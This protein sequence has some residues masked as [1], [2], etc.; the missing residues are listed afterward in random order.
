MP[1]LDAYKREHARLAAIIPYHP[2]A[3]SVSTDIELVSTWV[4]YMAKAVTDKLGLPPAFPQALSTIHSNYGF[5]VK[6]GKRSSFFNF[7]STYAAK[8]F[9][10]YV[11]AD[12]PFVWITTGR[13]EVDDTIV[14]REEMAGQLENA[15][16]HEYTPN[17]ARWEIPEPMR[18]YYAGAIGR[19][20][21]VES[22]PAPVSPPVRERP[23]P[24][25]PRPA[26]NTTGTLVTIADIAQELS[27]D[28]REARAL[29]RK[30]KVD[31]PGSSW[32]WDAADA[33]AI[34]KKLAS[35]HRR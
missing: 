28:A 20:L 14:I 31:K 16:E 5:Y 27:I 24:T 23:K 13:I 30:A 3:Q 34:K 32:A 1:T 18:S 10:D 7:H 8:K 4:D 33:A 21:P 15:I 19:A 6:R 26:K 11:I 12:L 2:F 25:A 22:A 29:L 17:E 9:L 35:L